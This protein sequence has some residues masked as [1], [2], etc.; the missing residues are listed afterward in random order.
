MDILGVMLNKQSQLSWT[1]SSVLFRYPSHIPG[2]KPQVE[3]AQTPMLYPNTIYC[4]AAKSSRYFTNFCTFSNG[5]A[6]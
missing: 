1:H 5:T 4:S 3:F 6:L 2:P